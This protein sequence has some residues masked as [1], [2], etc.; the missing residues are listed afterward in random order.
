MAR[1]LATRPALGQRRAGLPGPLGHL[2]MDEGDWITLAASAQP[3]PGYP[4]HIQFNSVHIFEWFIHDY[5]CDCFIC[6]CS[7]WIHVLWIRSHVNWWFVRLSIVMWDEHVLIEFL[8]C[9]LFVLLIQHIFG[10]I[11]SCVNVVELYI[12][13]LSWGRVLLGWGEPTECQRAGVT[14]EVFF[15]H[16]NLFSPIW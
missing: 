16:F 14:G 4:I 13:S 8:K 7:D 3:A 9:R 12:V 6:D 5:V 11:A 2:C 1:H 10:G 15:Y